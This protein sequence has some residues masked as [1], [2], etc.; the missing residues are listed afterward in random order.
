MGVEVND[1]CYQQREG[2]AEGF[3]Q[4]L[5]RQREHANP[6]D[7][8]YVRLWPQFVCVCVCVCVC[9]PESRRGGG[10]R[11]GGQDVGRLASGLGSP[12]DRIR[13]HG[14]ARGLHPGEHVRSCPVGAAASDL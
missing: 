4:G 2:D 6:R 1:G 3:A 9:E 13:K 11:K 7:Y 12:W 8:K 10:M 14:E 5:S